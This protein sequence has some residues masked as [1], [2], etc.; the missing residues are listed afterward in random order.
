MTSY[1]EACIDFSPGIE[2]TLIM[3]EADPEPYAIGEKKVRGMNLILKNYAVSICKM[4]TSAIAQCSK[5]IDE[6]NIVCKKTIKKERKIYMR[7]CGND[8][9]A[10]KLF[11]ANIDTSRF[12]VKCAF[13]KIVELSDESRLYNEFCEKYKL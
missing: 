9:E 2:Q 12:H 5:C 6:T 7:E 3:I 4:E 1:R 10:M 11:E 13:C 8:K